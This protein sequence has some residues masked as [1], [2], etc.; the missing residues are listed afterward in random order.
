MFSKGISLSHKTINE[1]A[2]FNTILGAHELERVM[3][4]MLEE[5]GN[6]DLPPTVRDGYCMAFIYFPVVFREQFSGYVP[7]VGYIKNP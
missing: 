3:P 1:L 5:A 4:H 2:S 7:K 6:V